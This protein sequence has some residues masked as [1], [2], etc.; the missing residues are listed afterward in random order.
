M[1][2]EVQTGRITAGRMAV[3]VV[4]VKEDSAW[5]EMAEQQLNMF[6]DEMVVHGDNHATTFIVISLT[7]LL[8][9]TNF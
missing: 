5:Q 9:P 3:A 6:G 2:N 1:K 8:H 4:V 7:S